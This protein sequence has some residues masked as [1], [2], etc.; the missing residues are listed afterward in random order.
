MVL[1][2]ADLGGAVLS[3]ANLCGAD[4]IDA[5]LSG[6]LLVRADLCGADCTRANFAHAHLHSAA[7]K[8]ARNLDQAQI[9]SA[10]GDEATRLPEGLT[11]PP[12]WTAPGDDD[13]P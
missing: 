2:G 10:F 7:L 3:D 12:A 11:R 4:L 9:E 13:A 6:A 1:S 8:D 5:D